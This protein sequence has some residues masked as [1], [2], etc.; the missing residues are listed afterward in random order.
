M[1][2]PKKADQFIEDQNRKWEDQ[3]TRGNFIKMKDVGRQGWQF[4]KRKAWTFQIQHDHP[5]KVLVMERIEFDHAEGISAYEWDGEPGAVEY[6]IGYYR[7]GG[8]QSGKGRWLWDP[9]PT[10]LIRP[11]A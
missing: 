5:V 10:G 11:V 3:R 9:L 2:A 4:W 1:H 6:Q 7:R 8:H